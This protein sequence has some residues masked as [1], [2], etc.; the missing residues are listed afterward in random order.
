MVGNVAAH[1]CVCYLSKL[2][3][4]F[5][6]FELDDLHSR[7]NILARWPAL[8]L[9]TW[10]VDIALIICVRRSGWY[11]T[12]RWPA[13]PNAH[14]CQSVAPT[15]AEGHGQGVCAHYRHC[16]N[17][18][19]RNFYLSLCIEAIHYCAMS[20]W[21]I[22]LVS[23][24]GFLHWRSCLNACVVIVVCIYEIRT[25]TSLVRFAVNAARRCSVTELYRMCSAGGG[26]T[27]NIARVTADGYTAVVSLHLAYSYCMYRLSTWYM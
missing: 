23:S 2:W 12:G 27:E 18:T 13:G 1:V 26:L 4:R 15:D 10:H 19:I 8:S 25:G 20:A 5:P 14:I 7:I 16:L 11:H 9:N 21:F 6:Q 3:L 17:H 24:W 22:L